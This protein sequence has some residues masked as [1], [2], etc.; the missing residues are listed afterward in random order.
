MDTSKLKEI[1]HKLSF[2][3]DYSALAVPV[4]IAIVG[5]V[6]IVVT[7]VLN[8]KL[9]VQI[10]KQSVSVGKK[11]KS[12]TSSVAPS[13]QSEVE[14]QYQLAHSEDANQIVLLSK[15][16]TMRE[17]LSYKIFPEPK[18][19]STLIFDEFARNYINKINDLIVRVN[20]R[21]CPTETEL[22]KSLGVT[23]AQSGGR[24]RRGSSIGLNEVDATIKDFICKS[25]AENAFVY[26]NPTNLAGYEFWNN[27]VYTGRLDAI[28]NCWYSQLGYWI[29]EDVFLTIEAANRGTKNIFTSPVKRFLALDFE[30]SG[31]KTNTSKRR[32]GQAQLSG[33]N[34]ARPRYVSSLDEALCEPFTSRYCDDKIDVVQFYL[35]VIIDDKAVFNFMKELCSAKEHRFRGFAGD[36]AEQIFKHNQITILES[37]IEPVDI[38]SPENDLYR[39]GEESVV[40]KLNL[41]C[42]YI[43]DKQVYD[44]I[45]PTFIKA[46][47]A[48]T[49]VDN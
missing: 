16:S 22:Q 13:Q 8:S 25:K 40:V 38:S 32:G 28:E 47:T 6:L 43:F 37:N 11:V 17:L 33:V 3:K 14:K 26:A 23:T 12:L 45:K 19:A 35:S 24:Q 7:Y 34:K 46:A 30:S 36:E 27:F 1:F 9:Q 4:I 42:E 20:G 48:P 15:Q 5:V 41:I 2:L 31:N 10:Q 29:T 44:E 39:Y 18:D 49:E 21:D